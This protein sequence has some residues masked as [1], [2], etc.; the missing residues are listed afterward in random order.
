MTT[1][2][3]VENKLS[4]TPLVDVYENEAE[5]LLVAELPGIQSEQV[6]LRVEKD[7]L[8]LETTGA[9][10]EW[11]YRRDFRLSDD[12]AADAVEAKLES[13]VLE[14]HLPKRAE[15]R[16]RRISVKTA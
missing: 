15:T 4:V 1:P 12:V 9:D 16:P 14:L 8:I 5:Y 10:E 11:E 13:G 7:V 6:E 2:A 3:K